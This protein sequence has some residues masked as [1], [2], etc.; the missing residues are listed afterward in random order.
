MN[1]LTAPVTGDEYVA[2]L[3]GRQ[4]A[5]TAEHP[6]VRPY[7]F[8]PLLE[9]FVRD[10]DE[11]FVTLPDAD[12]TPNPARKPREYRSAASLREERDRVQAQMDTLTD[13][14]PY[15]PAY[16]NLSPYARGK[17][18][19]RAGRKRFEKMDCDL[20]RYTELAKRRDA[21]NGRIASAEARERRA[22]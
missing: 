17:S 8:P 3:L 7:G 10:E 6:T 1:D 21:L 18:A 14:G 20:Q 16:V 15:D 22:A 4:A 13:T 9:W 11:P 12:P 19:A 5:W 2:V